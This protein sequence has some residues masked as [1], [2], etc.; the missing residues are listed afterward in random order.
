MRG[1]RLKVL[2]AFGLAMALSLAASPA[3]AGGVRAPE[4]DPSAGFASLTLL[5]GAALV[6]IERFGNRKK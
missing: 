2:A 4:L 1:R 6:L 5:G 3:H